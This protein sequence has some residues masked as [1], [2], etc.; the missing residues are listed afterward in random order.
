MLYCLYAC[1]ILLSC[2][3]SVVLS[4]SLRSSNFA[5]IFVFVTDS[6]GF[7]HISSCSVGAG[8]GSRGTV[9]SIGGNLRSSGD[10]FPCR[11]FCYFCFVVFNC[12]RCGVLSG[13]VWRPG[14]REKLRCPVRIRCPGRCMHNTG[15]GYPADVWY[16]PVSCCFTGIDIASVSLARA[17]R[18]HASSS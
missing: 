1:S 12:G 13:R 9:I 17:H 7:V 6:G 14:T 11:G 3:W 2:A 4:F 10:K 16:P 15:V 8:G 5:H 18:I